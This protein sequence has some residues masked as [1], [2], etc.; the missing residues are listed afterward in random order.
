MLN[1][2]SQLQGRYNIVQF[3]GQGGM[4]AVYLGADSRLS[5]RHVA[6]KEMNP[7]N[8]PLA[9]QSFAIRAFQQ[10]AEVLARLN[11]PT[12]ARVV[13]FFQENQYW[14]L[15]MEYVQ[16]EALD[17]ALSRFP[18]GLAEDQ[19]LNWAAQLAAALDYL[20]QQ[21]PPVIF[22]DLKPGNVMV[23]PDGTLKLIDF[24][25]ARYF[26]PGQSQDTYQLGTP[27]YAA[28][29]QYG[30]G[31]TDARSDV[32]SLGVMLH[33]LLTGYDPSLSP[34]NLPSVRSL[35]PDV[36]ER[37]AQAVE[38]AMRS[39]PSQRYGSVR[40]FVA[41]LGISISGM[42]PPSPASSSATSL[43][44][45]LKALP[46]LVL[47]GMG[48]FLAAGVFLLGWF[49]LLRGNEGEMATSTRLSTAVITPAT[50][51][52]TIIVE[53]TQIV[54]PTPAGSESGAGGRATAEETIAGETA[55]ETAVPPTATETVPPSTNTPVPPLPSAT[56]AATFTPLPPPPTDTPQPTVVSCSYSAA[57][58]FANTYQSYESQLGCP[59]G[60]AW[61]TWAAKEPFER[62]YMIWQEADDKIYVIYNNGNWARYDDIWVE[63]NAEFSCGVE[64]S[65]PTPKRGFGKI[66]CTKSGVQ[67]E[68]GN[69]TDGESG[70]ETM[71]QAFAN[72]L[73]WQTSVGRFVLFH[74]GTWRR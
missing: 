14:Y 21:N 6:I 67:R 12:I 65:P 27:G 48:I 74:N 25:I 68:L 19:V 45:R 32:Y 73:I 69:A 35:R 51:S 41:A 61:S 7:A 55:T 29:E 8:L 62:G 1:A 17:T 60:N 16:G 52:D 66:W 22:R 42:L 40:E 54:T 58:A 18:H 43:S 44:E 26:K 34:M 59:A 3:I 71:M 5:N 31:Q 10:E 53:V 15:V 47:I 2:G 20:H 57:N 23:Q 72:G 28:P 24:G 63:G 64:Q 36:S 38:Q 11:H 37:V 39:E 4:A 9:E 30:R 33:Q 70:E 46:L 13:D 56:P 49:G 50:I